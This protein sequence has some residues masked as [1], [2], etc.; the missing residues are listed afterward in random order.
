MIDIIKEFFAASP[1]IAWSIVSVLLAMVVIAALWEKVK[2]WWL[3][4]WMV[5][6]VIGRIARLSKDFN[7]EN[8]DDPESWFKAEKTLCRYYQEFIW[9]QGEYDFN[10]KVTYLTKAGDN[11]RSPTP[12]TIWILTALLV[13]VEAMGFS[14]VLA[15]WTIPGASENMQQ[16]GALAIAFMIS[17]ILVAFTHWAG[18]ELYVTSK[19]NNARKEW[20]EGGRK[21]KF[22]TKEIPLAR[23]QSE[24]DDEPGYTQ[25]VNRVGKSAKYTITGLTVLIV[26]VV[27]IGAT[28]VRGQVLEKILHDETTQR[29][30]VEETKK[31]DSDLPF[32]DLITNMEAKNEANNDGAD[33]DRRGGWGTF[34]VLAFIFVF[35]QILGIIFGYKWGFAGKNSKKAYEA[36]G[37]GRFSSYSDVRQYNKLIAD[38][39]Q[40]KLEALQQ[41]MMERNGDFGGQGFHTKKRFIDFMREVREEDAA[42]LK[43]ES[44][45]TRLHRERVVKNAAEMRDVSTSSQAQPE[46]QQLTLKMALQSLEVMQDKESKK[47]YI[48]SLPESLQSEVKNFLLA[49]KKA[50][51]ELD[52]LL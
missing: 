23:P 44:D 28:Y 52:E 35:L 12:F 22:G 4:T 38:V 29:V 39:A 46:T 27:A 30:Q 8:P 47:T 31:N 9:M 32:P 36:I 40:A 15:G 10:E 21:G 2:W 34:I 11:G 51:D 42:D 41:K 17:V 20:V 14:Y 13:Y 43:H 49:K 7:K 45:Y 33:I 50:A 37:S 3:N 18:H 25:L 5:F 16:A 6:P 19:V 48:Q 26:L 1:V 24:D